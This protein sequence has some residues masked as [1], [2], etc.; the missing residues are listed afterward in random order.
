MGAS[1]TPMAQL[2]PVKLLLEVLNVGLAQ[3]IGSKAMSGVANSLDERFKKA[4]TGDEKYKLGDK[5]KE[6][7]AKSLSKF[8]GKDSYSFGDISQAVAKRMNE[9][10][11]EKGGPKS[12]ERSTEALLDL[13]NNEALTDWDTKLL[14]AEAPKGTSNKK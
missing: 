2:L 1:F 7:L 4:I 14:Q 10:E 12:S 9:T 5:T 6:Q 11:K 8:T 13:V 3:D